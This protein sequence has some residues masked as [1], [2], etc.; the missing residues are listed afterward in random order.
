M[1]HMGG[2]RVPTASFRER[3]ARLSE[4][5]HCTGR[6]VHGVEVTGERQDWITL[7]SSSRSR[8]V[9]RSS[10]V[11]HCVH[12]NQHKSWAGYLPRP[13][14]GP[15]NAKTRRFAQKWCASGHSVVDRKEQ[16]RACFVPLVL[17]CSN[18]IRHHSSHSLVKLPILF[19]ES[20]MKLEVLKTEMEALLC[21]SLR[22]AGL[23][24]STLPTH[25]NT[26]SRA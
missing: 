12:W 13:I 25:K 18:L 8:E 14:C 4:N 7:K 9:G 10:Q 22:S 1:Y 20:T 19:D 26:R 24:N 15:Q 17:S 5:L 21:P 3:S 16:M 6:V 2:G 11:P 23:M